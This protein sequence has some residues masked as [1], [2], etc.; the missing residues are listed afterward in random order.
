MRRTGMTLVELVVVLVILAILTTIAVSMTDN[1]LE[2]ARFDATERTLDSIRGAIVGSSNPQDPLGGYLADVGALPAFLTDLSGTTNTNN[3]PAYA[4][5]STFSPTP[6]GML[7][8]K[9]LS[10]TDP[11]STV[12]QTIPVALAAGMRAPYLRLPANGTLVDGWG[13]AFKYSGAPLNPSNPVVV[14]SIGKPLDADSPSSPYAAPISLSIPT[15]NLVSTITV[16]LSPYGGASGTAPTKPANVVLLTVVNGVVTAMS[17]QGL[18]AVNAT[19][20]AP[21]STNAYTY[22]FPNTVTVPNGNRAVVA[23]QSVSGST[24]TFSPVTYLR[25][26]GGSISVSLS[27][28][29]Q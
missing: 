19:A 21:T 26:T 1:V 27:L 11:A 18:D 9:W 7:P 2:Q 24:P 29:L 14:T 17:A 5:Y 16:S 3:I 25:V 6:T 23:Y 8:V 12:M 28:V 13:N 20:L 22:T 4:V 10:A 15:T